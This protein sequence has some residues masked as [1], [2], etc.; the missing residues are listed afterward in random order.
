MERQTCP[1][2]A[3][4]VLSAGFLEN[5]ARLLEV[6]AFLDRIDRAGEPGT[7]EADFRYQAL[8]RALEI[9]S[10]AQENRA[11]ALLDAWSDP[12]AEPLESAKGLKGAHGAWPGER[13]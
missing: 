10:R 7:A 12:T 1:L 8:R 5:R 11:K 6:A 4:E 2:K 9:L 3:T 13:R